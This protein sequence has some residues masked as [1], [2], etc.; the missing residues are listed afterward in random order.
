L[1]ANRL[2]FL[3][4]SKIISSFYFDAV[5]SKGSGLTPSA[6]K[7]RT[8]QAHPPFNTCDAQITF[9]DDVQAVNTALGTCINT[10]T[11]STCP[12][13]T[14]APRTLPASTPSPQKSTP[15]VA[16]ARTPAPSPSP[17]RLLDEKPLPGP[18][19]NPPPQ[20]RQGFPNPNPPPPKRQGFLIAGT[21]IA[22]AVALV[23]GLVLFAFLTDRCRCRASAS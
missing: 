9:V 22:A 1:I 21:T 11:P 16:V 23:T 8:I 4:S 7:R 3:F 13:P 15:V 20:I 18:N 12:P 6:L 19:P 14:P 2:R 5:L 10:S 17:G